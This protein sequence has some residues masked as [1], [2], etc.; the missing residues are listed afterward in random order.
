MEIVKNTDC[1]RDLK[2]LQVYLESLAP[3]ESTKIDPTKGINQFR[4]KGLLSEET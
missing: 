4:S 2:I 1:M 3:S